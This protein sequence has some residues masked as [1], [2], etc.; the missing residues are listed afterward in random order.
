M[1][2]ETNGPCAELCGYGTLED[3]AFIGTLSPV[4]QCLLTLWLDGLKRHGVLPTSTWCFQWQISLQP[5][6]KNSA[7]CTSRPRIR[8]K[9]SHARAS[10]QHIGE[11][12][13]STCVRTLSAGVFHIP[14]HPDKI[15]VSVV[16]AARIV[17]Y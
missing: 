4:H 13:V 14:C 16:L 17:S 11:L 7:Q 12:A 1:V 3:R 6:I 2:D 9:T 15:K 8:S 10:V 5:G